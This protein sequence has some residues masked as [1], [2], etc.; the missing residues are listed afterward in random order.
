MTWE[1][2]A[3]LITIVSCLVAVGG[4]FAKLITTL[5]KLALS[6]D[7][8]ARSQ[9]AQKADAK[10]EHEHLNEKINR[11]R[12]RIDNHEMRLHDLEKSD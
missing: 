11:N 5:T 9:E 2:L 1:I 7:N 3:A 10:R 12:E 4:V 6:V 8:L